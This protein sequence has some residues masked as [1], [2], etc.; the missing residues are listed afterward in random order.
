MLNN[1]INFFPGVQTVKTDISQNT[2][3][4]ISQNTESNIEKNDSESFKDMFEKI[5]SKDIKTFEKQTNLK[6]ENLETENFDEDVER[7][8]ELFGIQMVQEI[9][10]VLN[11]SVESVEKA[12][13]NLDLKDVNLNVDD[14]LKKV[15][16][17]ISEGNVDSDDY[18]FSQDL[19]QDVKNIKEELVRKF[20][21]SD[22]KIPIL[23]E[24]IV[25]ENVET[26]NFV[27]KNNSFNFSYIQKD[28]EMQKGLENFQT[29]STT[30]PQEQLNIEEETPKQEFSFDNIYIQPPKEGVVI[31]EI[32]LEKFEEILKEKTGVDTEDIMKQITK[33][34]VIEKTKET[35]QIEFELH[36]ASLGTVNIV[37]TSGKNGIDAKFVTQ[38][39]IAKEAMNIQM[40]ILL[41]KFE[42]QNVKVNS[43]EVLTR[44]QA[45]DSSNKENKENKE[46]NQ[47]KKHRH[48]NLDD[49]TFETN[50]TDLN[51]EMMLRNGNA[52]DF[53]A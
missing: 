50:E 41:E 27:I 8:V 15:I 33:E 17:F 21:L 40:N 36:P 5:S 44:D 18:N 22:E 53:N 32:P 10:Q 29:Q 35:T 28:V 20:D 1:F 31:K 4:N 34:V 39:E 13:D 30:F 11:V 49:E 47:H 43:I 14:N 46:T 23:Q 52:I 7:Q 6:D 45:F 42:M 9:A 3:S 37:L 19:F 24:N 16:S 26:K 51:I 48:I 12:L 38:T 25:E 2:E